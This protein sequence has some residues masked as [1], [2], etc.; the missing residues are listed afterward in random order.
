MKE[1]LRTILITPLRILQSFI[2]PLVPG[3]NSVCIIPASSNNFTFKAAVEAG[4][5]SRSDISFTLRLLKF[6]SLTISIRTS[7]AKAFATIHN[8]GLSKPNSISFDTCSTSF[9]L[10]FCY[11]TD[12]LQL[13]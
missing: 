9:R 4:I 5:P 2:D 12:L 1:E 3:C 8:S 11:I 6:K 7:E 10:F 13:L